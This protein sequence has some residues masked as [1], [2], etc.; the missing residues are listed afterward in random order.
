VETEQSGIRTGVRRRLREMIQVSRSSPLDFGFGNADQRVTALDQVV[1]TDHYRIR[2]QLGRLSQRSGSIVKM[3]PARA[4]VA[5]LVIHKFLLYQLSC[6]FELMYARSD[7]IHERIGSMPG[8][9][10]SRYFAL[11]IVSI[12]TV[13]AGKLS[14]QR[15]NLF[16]GM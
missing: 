16:A 5:A 2:K 11:R 6:L 9:G 1:R 10:F 7:L 15:G 12:V 8:S 3:L 4:I 14:L 13:P